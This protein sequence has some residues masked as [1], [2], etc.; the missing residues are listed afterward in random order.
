[1]IVLVAVKIVLL[2]G[3]I[4]KVMREIGSSIAKAACCLPLYWVAMVGQEVK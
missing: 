1:M 4:M 3:L 2:V